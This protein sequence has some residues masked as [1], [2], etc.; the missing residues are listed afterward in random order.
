MIYALSLDAW[1]SWVYDVSTFPLCFSLSGCGTYLGGFWLS[2]LDDISFASCIPYDVVSIGLDDYI[3]VD[4]SMN[5]IVS[6]ACYCYCSYDV[7]II[8]V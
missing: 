5:A 2:W 7:S 8:V 1:L 6:L 4:W 3:N